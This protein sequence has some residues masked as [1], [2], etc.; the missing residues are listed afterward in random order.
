MATLGITIDT[1]AV[2]N[3]LVFEYHL[4]D[5]ASFNDF[6]EAEGSMLAEVFLDTLED[7]DFLEIFK[8]GYGISLDAVQC[9]IYTADGTEIYRGEIN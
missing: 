8:T 6:G 3:T 1:A 4:P 2:G 5:D 7:A 9:A